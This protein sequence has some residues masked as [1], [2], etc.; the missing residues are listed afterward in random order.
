MKCYII[1]RRVK[2]SMND[3]KL[4]IACLSETQAQVLV[5]SYGEDMDGSPRARMF[6]LPLFD[7]AT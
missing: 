7:T 6:E 4:T 5:A 3:W 2:W 1:E